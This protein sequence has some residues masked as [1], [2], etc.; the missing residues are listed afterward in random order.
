VSIVSTVKGQ[1]ATFYTCF[2]LFLLRISLGVI[3]LTLAAR[4]LLEGGWKAW[5]KLGGMLPTVVRGPLEP[6]FLQFWENPVILYLVIGASI[7]IGLSMVLGLFVRLGALGGALMMVGFYL[8]TLPPL[9]GWINYYFVYFG[10]FLNFL[11][12]TPEYAFGLDRYLRPYKDRYPW[13]KWIVA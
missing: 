9:F 5:M 4:L 6:V 1:S 11:V 3:M 7:A 8:A 13:L 10:A 12:I 2:L